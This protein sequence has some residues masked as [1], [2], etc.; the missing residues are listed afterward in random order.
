MAEKGREAGRDPRPL[1]PR[2]EAAVAVLRTAGV[3]N[4]RLADVLRPHGLTPT[5]YNVLRVARGAGAAGLNCGA[6]AD[7]M[8]DPSPDVTRLLDRLQRRGLI[9]RRRDAADRRQVVSAVSPEGLRLLEVLDPVVEEFNRV[10]MAS[11]D[12]EQL[13]ELLETLARIRKWPAL[14]TE[15]FRVL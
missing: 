6:V 8:L 13:Q 11:L 9:E 3:L 12:Q 14:A 10:Q 5:Q 1:I 7:R 2:E 4:R 15:S